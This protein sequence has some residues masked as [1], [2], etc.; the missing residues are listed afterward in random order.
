MDMVEG[1]VV[2]AVAVQAGLEM[3]LTAQE[4]VDFLSILVSSE[5][6]FTLLVVL[7]VEVLM[8]MWL[9]K[10]AVGAAATPAAVGATTATMMAA[11]A[12]GRTTSDPTKSILAESTK[13]TAG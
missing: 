10:A 2:P 9:Q 11:V 6:S 1:Q 3:A 5:A 8:V 12:V 4:V 7:V 13:T